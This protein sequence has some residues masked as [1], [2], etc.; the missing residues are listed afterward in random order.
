MKHLKHGDRYPSISPQAEEGARRLDW[1]LVK[2]SLCTR[3]SE[4]TPDEVLG[5]SRVH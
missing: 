4:Q 5:N 2:V 3:A 1:G